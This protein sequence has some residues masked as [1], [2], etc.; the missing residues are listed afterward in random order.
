MKTTIDIPEKTLKEAMRHTGASTKR[1]AVV[2]AM[3]EFNRR[4]RLGKLA[5]EMGQSDT[6]MSFE[7]LMTQR[8]RDK[9]R[10]YR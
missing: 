4:E 10:T 5:D 1:D 3:E 8:D 6:F 2:Q 9:R 7:Q